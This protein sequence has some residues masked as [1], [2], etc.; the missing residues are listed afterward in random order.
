MKNS[1]T[2]ESIIQVLREAKPSPQNPGKLTDDI[3]EQINR[4][5]NKKKMVAG[6]NENRGQWTIFIGVRNAM[7]VAAILLVGVFIYQQ[8]VI[9]SK[10]S[11]L[12]RA[13]QQS[14]KM[15]ALENKEK[16]EAAGLEQV[17][18]QKLKEEKINI[19]QPLNF[20]S[21]KKDR[22]LFNAFIQSYYQ[23]QQENRQLKDK[24]M[25]NY[26]TFTEKKI[27]KQSKL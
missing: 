10:V 8:W 20:D 24:L 27:V 22:T 3:M 1:K 4:P 9:T 13:L 2:Y 16:T 12:E 14:N 26:S 6:L 25:E 23:L 19:D 18:Y 15:V 7:A 11:N 5:I 17:L 21:V